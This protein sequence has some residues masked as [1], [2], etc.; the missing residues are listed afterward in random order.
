MEIYGVP[1]DKLIRRQSRTAPYLLVGLLFATSG[2]L[3]LIAFHENVDP[4]P[5]RWLAY[6]A[7]ASFPCMIL[8]TL[9]VSFRER[10]RDLIARIREQ[11]RFHVTDAALIRHR[12]AEAEVMIRFDEITSISESAEWL[13]V[14]ASTGWAIGIPRDVGRYDEL[15]A[16]LSKYKPIVRAAPRSR[17]FVAIMF[18][19]LV[20]V[21]ALVLMMTTRDHTVRNISAALVVILVVLQY[22]V[23]PLIQLAL[24]RNTRTS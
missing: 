15:R 12:P 3:L 16:T 23:L 7:A 17:S 24:R 20:L 9:F 19:P 11:D 2:P 22:M 4:V 14:R 21:V 8:V 1:R 5:R 13:R 6:F 10:S 18:V